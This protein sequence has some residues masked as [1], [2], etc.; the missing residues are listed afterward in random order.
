MGDEEN[1]IDINYHT[2]KQDILPIFDP[3]CF[4][5]MILFNNTNLF[6]LYSRLMSFNWKLQINIIAEKEGIYNVIRGPFGLKKKES[7]NSPKSSHKLQLL[8]VYK[9]IN[10]FKYRSL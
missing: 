7:I 8:N 10:K 5:K 1:D 3:L 2:N 4:N 6:K 9:N